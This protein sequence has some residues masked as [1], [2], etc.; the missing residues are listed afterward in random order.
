MKKVLLT[1]ALVSGFASASLADAPTVTAGGKVDFQAT[2]NSQK[3]TYKTDNTKQDRRQHFAT[4][5]RASVKAQGMTDYGMAYGAM[6]EFGDKTEMGSDDTSSTSGKDVEL[7]DTML[8]VE[9]G[10][11]RVEMGSMAGASKVMKVGAENI[12]RATGGIGGDHFDY[13]NTSFGFVPTSTATNRLSGVWL[14]SPRLPFDVSTFMSR[15]NKVSFYTPEVNGLQ[16][17]LSFS[18]DTGEIGS[19]N[20]ISSR[21]LDAGTDPIAFSSRHFKNAFS[22]GLK[23]KTQMDQVALELGATA[24]YGKAERKN[25]TATLDEQIKNV[26]AYTIGG[27]ANYMNY[28]LAASYGDWGRSMNTKETDQFSRA[29]TKFYTLGG[30]YVQGPVGLSVTYFES[31]RQKNKTETIS[32]GADYALAA[33]MLPYVEGTFF[34]LKPA[35]GVFEIGR[36]HV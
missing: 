10:M 11:G 17:G 3:D 7:K 34:K 21:F 25:S 16:A 2:F 12:A 30:S 33:G 15:Y 23:Y 32:V 27:T 18:V 26:R 9:T 22:G 29:S 5:S 8:F 24:Q 20:A 36:A 1:T 13:V 4:A 19:S 35:T 6:V 28:T 14:T 31:K